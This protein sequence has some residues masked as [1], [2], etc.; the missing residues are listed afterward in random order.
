[1]FDNKYLGE[2]PASLHLLSVGMF[3]WLTTFYSKT[4]FYYIYVFV[5]YTVYMRKG[6]RS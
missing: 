2:S 5:L 3:K 1:M 6:L 4:N